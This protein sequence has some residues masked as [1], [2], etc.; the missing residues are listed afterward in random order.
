MT[1]P[2]A[3]LGPLL[4]ALLVAILAMVVTLGFLRLNRSLT[5]AFDIQVERN[6]P[7]QLYFAGD[8]G[9]FSERKQVTRS[10][11]GGV[12][13][14]VTVSRDSLNKTTQIRLDPTTQS[15]QFRL[16]P[17][18]L[19]SRWADLSFGGEALRGQFAVVE[20][21]AIDGVDGDA[22][23][24]HTTGKDPHVVIY[25]PHELNKVRNRELMPTAWTAALISGLV[26]LLGS[27][28]LSTLQPSTR[29]RLLRMVR[30]G[31][32]IPLLVSLA[33]TWQASKN[34]TSNPIVGDGVQNL[35]M[36]VNLF[37]Y[38]TLSLD[39]N[40]QPRPTNFREP[41]NPAVVAL[42]LNLVKQASVHLP[43]A[44]FRAG[45][46]TRTVKMSNLLWVFTGLLGVWLMTL[47]LGGS[48]ISG[49]LATLLSYL[50][51]FSASG[52]IDTL[53]TEVSTAALMIWV[54]YSLVRSV[55]KQS[56]LWFLISGMLMGL[57]AL[58]KGSFAYIGA[59][60]VP[61]LMLALLIARRPDRFTIG[62][63]LTWGAAMGA[64][65][66]LTITPWLVRNEVQFGSVRLAERGGLVL[67][68]RALR[69]EMSNDEVLGLMYYNSP[70]IY[71]QLVKGTH[72]APAP[73]DY[74][75]GGRWQRINRGLSSFWETDRR[76]AYAGRPEEAISF[77]FHTAA[78]YEHRL[79]L[80][81]AQGIPNADQLLEDQLRA[82]AVAMIKA[83]PWRH[84]FMTGPFLWH[85][86]WGFPHLE[87]P[88]LSVVLQD[89][90]RE[91]TNLLA[92][93]SLFGVFLYGL[94]GRR[95]QWL[96]ATVLPIGLLMFYAFLTHNLARYNAPA[97]PL[98]LMALVLAVR[99]LWVRWRQRKPQGPM[100]V[101][102]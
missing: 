102:G 15:G 101:V 63:V 55:Q 2:K 75:R 51:F 40:E 34:I 80:L 65:F 33:L 73:G 13:E 58:A 16:G 20:D 100:R 32:A 24:M 69:N 64:A 43:H 53:Y 60:A 56:M 86:F 4:R 77:H 91:M 71:K 83:R 95:A 47:R 35:L 29:A 82:E 92:G 39:V 28:L 31:A 93:L 79:D 50:F 1:H 44:E 54:S 17:I 45:S 87:V 81:Q 30:Y 62:K 78:M 99:T 25:L 26:W 23:L 8:D 5:V 89:L 21:L 72:L 3:L 88:G 90:V 61:L 94:F 19:T 6:G 85:G 22:L 46:M 67:W 7:F 96:A 37:K 84:L 41:L 66:L 76:A 57:L 10:V 97:Y 68:G 42:H 48:N 74:E 70:S 12:M 38:N 9:V 49:A 27:W 18:R 14:H 59:V 52:Y 98:M 36:S 11:H